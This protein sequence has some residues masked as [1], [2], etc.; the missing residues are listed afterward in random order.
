MLAVESMLSGGQEV[1]WVHDELACVAL[2]NIKQDAFQSGSPEAGMKSA[3][4]LS[5]A[6]WRGAE[7]YNRRRPAKTNLA[8]FNNVIV[9]GPL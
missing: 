5:G 7:A 2:H 3:P 4:R 9:S 6:P 1:K 8:R